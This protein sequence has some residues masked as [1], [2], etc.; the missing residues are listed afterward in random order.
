MSNYTFCFFCKKPSDVAICKECAKKYRGEIRKGLEDRPNRKSSYWYYYKC[1]CGF[2]SRIGYRS[3]I[4]YAIKEHKGMVTCGN[5]CKYGIPSGRKSKSIAKR[6]GSV[7]VIGGCDIKESFVFNGE[8]AGVPF[9]ESMSQRCG[10]TDIT[11]KMYNTCLQVSI[12][13]GWEGWE[14]TGEKRK[15]PLNDIEAR[16]IVETDKINLKNIEYLFKEFIEKERLW[17]SK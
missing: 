6:W 14:V 12:E 13:S 11:C 1:K 10:E 4:D 16:K 3:L 7:H 8:R 2:T 5:C 15:Q 17:Q 9:E